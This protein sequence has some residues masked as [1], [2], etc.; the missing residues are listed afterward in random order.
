MNRLE[1]LRR[2]PGLQIFHYCIVNP[3][4]KCDYYIMSLYGFGGSVLP[5]LGC[6]LMLHEIEVRLS[7][8]NAELP[9]MT[10]ISAGRAFLQDTQS[11]PKQ[12]SFKST[13]KTYL[14][15]TPTLTKLQ[16]TVMNKESLIFRSSTHGSIHF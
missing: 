12:S 9:T 6:E 13:Q 3:L 5:S 11:D 10:S 8:V 1:I 16:H 2:L 15:R 14:D 7:K 4:F